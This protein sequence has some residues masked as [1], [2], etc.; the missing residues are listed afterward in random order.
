MLFIVQMNV[1]QDNYINFNNYCLTLEDM[2]T[3]FRW[4][5]AQQE[6]EDSTGY[7]ARRIIKTNKE[8]PISSAYLEW[9]FFTQEMGSHQL[10]EDLNDAWE[11]YKTAVKKD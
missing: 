10:I 1:I 4:L 7:Y 8:K 6:R 9:Y 3:F 11:E 5:T 2:Q